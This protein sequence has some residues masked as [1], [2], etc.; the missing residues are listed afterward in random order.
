MHT[1]KQIS[2]PLH[3]PLPSV[4][5]HQRAGAV[6][7]DNAVVSMKSEATELR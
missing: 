2:L 6:D 4:Y 1:N 7:F 3:E 5:H